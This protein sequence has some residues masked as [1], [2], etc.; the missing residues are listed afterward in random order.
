MNKSADGLVLSANEI[1]SDTRGIELTRKV[2]HKCERPT[3]QSHHPKAKSNERGMAISIRCTRQT[4]I[5]SA[6]RKWQDFSGKPS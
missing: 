4:N 5:K 6:V 3:Y 2:L 1:K